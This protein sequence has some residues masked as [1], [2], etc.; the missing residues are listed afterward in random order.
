MSIIIQ[1]ASYVVCDSTRIKRDC[2]VLVE[3]QRIAAVGSGVSASTGATV[4]DGRG[5]VVIPGLI[6]AHTHLYQNFLKGISPGIPLVPWCNEVLFP[7]VG[8]IGAAHKAGNLRPGYLWSAAAVL[9]MIHGGTTCCLNMDNV[10]DE[11]VTAWEDAGFRGIT[12][13]T[14]TNKWVPAELRS[15]E[16]EMRRKTLEFVEQHHHPDGL[17]TVF[18]APS[19][20]F[21]C[22]D[23]F[24]R[25]AGEQARV[26]DLGMQIHI[27]ETAGEIEDSLKEYGL[28][29]V[30]K[31]EQLGLLEPRLSAVHCC[32]LTDKEIDLLAKSGATAVHCPKSNMKLA[33]GVMRTVDM[34]KAGIPI[35][36][37]NDGCASNDLLDMWEEMR[38]AMMLARVSYQDANALT[39]ADV[40]RMATT[41][42]ARTCRVEAGAIEPGKLADM[43][44]IELKSAHLRPF[45]GDDLLNMLVFCVRADDVRD[46]IIDGQVVMRDRKVTTLDEPAILNEADAVEAPLYAGRSDYK[47]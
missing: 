8:A 14:L 22:D 15:A 2:D 39:P 20:L 27:S 17:T 35:S 12:A 5:C 23:P 42:A 37:G 21:L 1:N 26:H 19:T 29:P 31:L 33:D 34:K 11:T 43:A 25:W 45:H 13:Y 41:D 18:L 6:N 10:T 4:L 46:T 16:A 40:F 28:R 38:A 9:E 3:G 7:T 24:L 44:V 30:E 47:F 32:H 36:L